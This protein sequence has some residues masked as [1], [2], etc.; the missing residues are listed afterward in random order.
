MAEYHSAE[1]L[2]VLKDVQDAI[3]KINKINQQLY[4][5]DRNGM[6]SVL[7]EAKTKAPLAITA[8]ELVQGDT[9]WMPFDAFSDTDLYRKLAQYKSGLEAYCIE[10][11]GKELY[12]KLRNK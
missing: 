9:R 4:C 1:E 10:K 3:E 8:V 7:Q 12:D 5:P 11:A 2:Q 6:I